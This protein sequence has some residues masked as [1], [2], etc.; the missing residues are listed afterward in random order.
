MGPEFTPERLAGLAKL[1]AASRAMGA[2]P[3]FSNPIVIDEQGFAWVPDPVA[4]PHCSDEA[5]GCYVHAG[6]MLGW[7][8]MS[9]PAHDGVLLTVFGGPRADALEI[10]DAVAAFVT[11]DGLKALIADLEAIAASIE[12]QP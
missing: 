3:P 10:E 9:L 7:A 2:P 4:F 5:I 1:A 12:A 6:V 8:P 11:R